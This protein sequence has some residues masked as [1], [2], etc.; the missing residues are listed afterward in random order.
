VPLR[1]RRRDWFF[2][3]AFSFFAFSSFFSDAWA[4]LGVDF[5]ADSPSFWARAN[6]WYAAGTDP[7]FLSH[8][9]HLRIQTFLSGFVFGPFYLLLVY[10]FVAGK[11]WIRLPA[12]FYTAAMLYG[13]VVFLGSEFLGG[14][15]P[16]NLPKFLGFNLPYLIVPLALVYRLRR[17]HP[18][19]QAMVVDATR[20]RRPGARL[21]GT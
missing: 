15:P 14:L 17:E 19:S 12:F 4:G 6:Y 5:S 10:A 9:I 1:E 13:M 7:Y 21:T 3:A 8:P 11:D 2:V 18:F 16:T 20:G